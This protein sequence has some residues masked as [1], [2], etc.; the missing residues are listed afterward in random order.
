MGYASRVATATLGSWLL[1]VFLSAAPMP[2]AAERDARLAEA[3]AAWRRGNAHDTV[4]I[5]RALLELQPEDDEVRGRLG[6][7]LLSLGHVHAA[8]TMLREVL[9][10]HPDDPDVRGRLADAYLRLGR[11]EDARRVLRES[12]DPD[13]AAINERLGRL[14]Y[15]DGAFTTARRHT[16]A[17]R[18]KSP[19]EWRDARLPDQTFLH[20]LLFNARHEFFPNDLDDLSTVGIS[21]LRRFDRLE[22][23]A[24]TAQA[25]RFAS[26]TP[27]GGY[28]AQYGAGLTYYPTLGKRLLV[29]VSGG[30]PVSSLPRF[31]FLVGA[32]TSLG[33]RGDAGLAYS[34]W[35]FA[36]GSIV[37]M[38]RPTV[39]V[40]LTERFS[41][42][43]LAWLALVEGPGGQN[44]TVGTTFALRGVYQ[45]RPRFAVSATLVHGLETTRLL[46][47]TDV[48]D[49]NANSIA[50]AFDWSV[51]RHLGLAPIVRLE[52]RS[53]PYGDFWVFAPE[54]MTA[55]RW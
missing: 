1:S 41:L 55:W 12:P 21:Y 49:V 13:A 32:G 54:V 10:R 27:R 9:E 52:H 23:T 17:W 18:R 30:A 40:V 20:Q 25:R 8:E 3:T 24:F 44:R 19:D 14:A 11:L 39:T 26:T 6:S 15:W 51:T 29:E 37:H 36:D 50:L 38:L 33:P 45:V 53:L 7:V 48:S 47:A 31:A 43:V 35:N 4:R 2:T 42:G 5:Y 46:N 28:N 22:L 34:Y 16:D